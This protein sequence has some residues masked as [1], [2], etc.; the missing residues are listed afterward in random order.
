MLS[1][2]NETEL[3][4][5]F[6]LTASLS[7]SDAVQIT[8]SSSTT[9]LYV[10]KVIPSTPAE[11]DHISITVSTMPLAIPTIV[12]FDQATP[13]PPSNTLL[14]TGTATTQSTETSFYTLTL[15]VIGATSVCLITTII[16]CTVLVA[17][18]CQRAKAQ[19]MVTNAVEPSMFQMVDHPYSGVPCANTGIYD[20]VNPKS[21]PLPDLPEEQ[22]EDMNPATFS[23]NNTQTKTYIN[24]M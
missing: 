16:S 4:N 10:M 18:Y 1:L 15:V 11:P 5:G 22:Y 7:A 20:F 23:A 2:V 8:F 21:D 13:Q 12:N 19:R 9:E 3:T 14:T 17:C 24:M 6:T